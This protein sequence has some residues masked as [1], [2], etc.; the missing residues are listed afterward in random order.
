MENKGLNYTCL[1]GGG[2]IRG[3]AYIGAAKALE[4]LD[5]KPKR[6]VGS[7]VGSI[8]AS[9]LAIGYDADGIKK[10]F[11]DV[12]YNLFKDI[13]LG[14][15][16]LIALSKGNVFLDWLRDAIESKFYGEKY[17]K[18]KNEPVKFKDIDNDLI[19]ITTDL[20]NFQCQEFSKYATP[21][22]EI[23][24]AIRISSCMPGL[25]KPVEYEG[26]ILVDGDLQKSVPMW[27]LSPNILIP[28][29]RILEFR[30][31]GDFN[32]DANMKN[33]MDYANAVYSCMTSMSTDFIKHV[34]GNKDK[35]DYIV[36]NTGDILIV[37]FNTPMEKR[38]EIVDMGY[39]QTLDYFRKKLPDK[40]KKILDNY[41]II[42]GHLL[43]IQNQ[44][45]LNNLKKVQLEIG[46]L[47]I[48]LSELYQII[49]LANYND[50]KH[51]KDLF[52]S[53]LSN[54][55]IFGIVRLKNKKTVEIFLSELLKTIEFKIDE[56][57][58]YIKNSK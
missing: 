13:Q 42:Q 47:F 57:D 49:D 28:D 30:L 14:F 35:F 41:N 4:E 9:L 40:K 10:S 11:I 38:E 56:L 5:I 27:K 37:D 45:K 29:E 52:Y 21:N 58:C 54:V 50:I 19:I 51:F 36:L 16:P 6:F 33:G 8:I 22:F 15:G 46:E 24:S 44:I 31:E 20:E 32:K 2:A 3:L 39:N 55:K 43:R 23:A 34:Y 25:M 53:N 7:S 48:N 12:N 1:F 17:E 26:R 18:G